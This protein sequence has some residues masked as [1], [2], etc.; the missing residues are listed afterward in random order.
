MQYECVGDV[1]N[2]IFPFAALVDGGSDDEGP[3]TKDQWRTADGEGKAVG[4]CSGRWEFGGK[5]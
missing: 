1:P 5:K 2:V 4:G 3:R